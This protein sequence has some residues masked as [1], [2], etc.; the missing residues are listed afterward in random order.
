VDGTYSESY[1]VNGYGI[2]GVASELRD[3][4]FKFITTDLSV[5]VVRKDAA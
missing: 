4:V 5:P 1:P 3:T 2:S